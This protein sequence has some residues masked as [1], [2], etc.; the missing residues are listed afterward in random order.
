MGDRCN[1]YWFAESDIPCQYPC[2]GRRIFNHIS[3]DQKLEMAYPESC[4]GRFIRVERPGL[5]ESL[6]SARNSRWVNVNE[7]LG[8]IQ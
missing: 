5:F 4:I 1:L 6:D 3:E 2:V 8:Y 7:H